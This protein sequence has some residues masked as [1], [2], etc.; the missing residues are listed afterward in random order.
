MCYSTL[1]YYRT[2]VGWSVSLDNVLKDNSMYKLVCVDPDGIKKG[3]SDKFTQRD[4][5]AMSPI[6][7]SSIE[8]F[9]AIG[10]CDSSYAVV[11]NI[12]NNDWDLI[13]S[14]YE[15][16]QLIESELCPSPENKL[17]K[18]SNVP[19]TIDDTVISSYDTMAYSYSDDIDFNVPPNDATPINAAGPLLGDVASDDE[20]VSS[21]SAMQSNSDTV[22]LFSDDS[23]PRTYTIHES[24]TVTH[25]H[26]GTVGSDCHTDSTPV[27]K[28]SYASLSQS[29]VM[30]NV[31]DPITQAEIKSIKKINRDLVV[32]FNKM[33]SWLT[34]EKNKSSLLEKEL[35]KEKDAIAIILEEQNRELTKLK[36][37][38]VHKDRL[39][40]ALLAEKKTISGE[41]EIKNRKVE[42]LEKELKTLKHLMAQMSTEINTGGPS[43]RQRKALT[44]KSRFVRAS[45]EKEL[46]QKLPLN[47][48]TGT[49]IENGKSPT[50]IDTKPARIHR[51]WPG[52]ESEQHKLDVHVPTEQ[53]KPRLSRD[54]TNRVQHIEINLSD[55]EGESPTNVK[56]NRQN[57]HFE[58]EPKPYA[59][60]RSKYYQ[61]PHDFSPVESSDKPTSPVTK[62]PVCD[63]ER[64]RGESPQ[65]LNVH[66]EACLTRRGYH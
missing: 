39:I 47:Q 29:V 27:E 21:G 57:R 16:K 8:S 26:T 11:D 63:M 9:V 55:L 36:E 24:A 40:R 50:D 41:L 12:G 15:S 42:S 20:P 48:V 1:Y 2:D 65:A 37:D 32:K 10:D 61:N 49:K 23:G 52:D 66:I 5:L 25:E 56:A 60:P 13:K 54:E 44:E 4:L 38:S 22:E 34:E 7:D 43:P 58:V 64:P 45:S 51:K 31:P 18:K 14:M 3:E 33:S 17:S 28:G 59:L 6:P 19:N 30:P 53:H 62:C 46:Q 35:R